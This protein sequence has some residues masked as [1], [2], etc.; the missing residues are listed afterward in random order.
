MAIVKELSLDAKQ[1]EGML[2]T[3]WNIR[4]ATI[5]P[6]RRINLTP[7]WFGWAGGKI[8]MHARG[9]KV[10]NLRRNPNCTMLIDRN[11][12]FP[13]LQGIMMLGTARVLEDAAAEKADPHLT[14]VQAQMGRKYNGGHGRLPVDNPPP[15]SATAQGSTRRWIVFTPE[16]IVT[17]DNFKLGSLRE[18]QGRGSQ[19]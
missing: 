8:Y 17:W 7:M 9:Q 5:G 19:G 14:E 13:E 3:E 15:F 11:E 18:G 16:T 1:I 6:G 10:I 2:Q 12:K 4:V